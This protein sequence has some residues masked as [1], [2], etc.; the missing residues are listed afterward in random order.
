MDKFTD[1]QTLGAALAT[2]LGLGAFARKWFRRDSAEAD[3]A[4][5]YAQALAT[6]RKEH[7]AI[8][9][10]LSKCRA[11][12]EKCEEQLYTL[13]RRVEPLERK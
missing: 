13:L 6:V 9:D 5:A 3:V 4:A 1:Y 2:L 7:E 8:W 11:H 12:H 10:N